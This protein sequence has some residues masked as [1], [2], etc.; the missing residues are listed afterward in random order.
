MS[1]QLPIEL[2]KYKK[3]IDLSKWDDDDMDLN[4]EEAN[5][6]TLQ[7][8]IAQRLACHYTQ[9]KYLELLNV[10]LVNIILARLLHTAVQYRGQALEV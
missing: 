5:A 1:V 3:Y 9:I 6:K 4:I 2:Q 8:Y 7:T 10:S